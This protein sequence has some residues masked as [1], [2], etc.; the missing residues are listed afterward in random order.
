MIQDSSHH[1]NITDYDIVAFDMDFTI[2]NYK[3]KPFM[4]LMYEAAAVYMIG[5]LGYPPELIPPTEEE[6]LLYHFCS[7]WVIDKKR[8]WVLKISEDNEVLLA[9]NG[10]DR[11]PNEE[12]VKEFG[13]QPKINPFCPDTLRSE[14]Y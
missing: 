12:L 14:E 7:R 4:K 5:Y 2:I 13:E 9:Y 8:L 1:R 6:H 3:F 10:Y 11:V